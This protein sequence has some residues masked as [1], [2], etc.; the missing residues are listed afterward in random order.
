MT[1]TLEAKAYEKIKDKISKGNYVP[2]IHLTEAQLVKDLEMSRTPIRRALV[3]LESE[4]FIKIESHHGAVVQNIKVSM[5]EVIH[6]VEVRLAYL[7]FALE[8]AERKKFV[9]QI[10][11]FNDCLETMA[12][13]IEQ[14]NA[15]D[16]YNTLQTFDQLILLSTNNMLMIESLRE[17]SERFIIGFAETTFQVRMKSYPETLKIYQQFIDSM[18]QQDYGE[19]IR[20]IEKISTAA[21]LDFI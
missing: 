17:L 5:T 18:E 13:C 21:V 12:F 4:G 8:K 9:Y 20:L 7:K 3:R 1:K 11:S 16:Y 19:S 15:V 6:I 2:G 10:E 14:G